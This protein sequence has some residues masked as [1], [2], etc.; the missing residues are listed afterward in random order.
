MPWLCPLELYMQCLFIQNFLSPYQVLKRF[1]A[2]IPKAVIT[3]HAH[4]RP[5]SHIEICFTLAS[6]F[7]TFVATA[8]EIELEPEVKL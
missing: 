2:P 1:Q 4:K 8:V 6:D 7:V 3:E 5:Y